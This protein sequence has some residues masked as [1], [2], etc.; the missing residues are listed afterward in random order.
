MVLIMWLTGSGKRRATSSTAPPAGAR[1]QPPNAATVEDF[2][3]TIHQE[4]AATRQPISPT[5]LGRPRAGPALLVLPGSREYSAL[6]LRPF[7]IGLSC[8]KSRAVQGASVGL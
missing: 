7:H 5:N 8:G 1:I 3:Q 2:K 6:A 4:P